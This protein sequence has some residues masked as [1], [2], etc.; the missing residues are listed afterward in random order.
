[1]PES[2]AI[3]TR[4]PQ[5][6]TLGRRTAFWL[7]AGTLALLLFASSAPSPLYVVYQAEW[8]FST[9]TLTSV[10]AVY[11]LG[12]L[13]ALVITGSV[14]DHVGRRP[15]LLVGLGLEVVGM[16]L[17]ARA[18]DVAWLFAAR[19]LQGVA[20]GIAMGAI[21][22]ALIDLEPSARL[23]ATLGVAA[24]MGG[25]AAG[26]LG[27]G[28]LVQYGPDPTRLIFWMLLGAFV[29]A[30]ILASALPETVRRGGPWV[31]SLRPRLAVPANLR[32]AF[33]GTIPCLVATWAL[34]GLILSL[35]PSLTAGV[36]GD[37]SHVA[38][39]LPIFIMAGISAVASVRLR[40][41]HARSTAR[42]GLGAMIVGV[43]V[44]LGALAAGSTA[45]FLVA[46]A[47]AGLG[48]GPAFAGAFRALS[49]RAGAAERGGLVSSILAVSYLAF[50]L[51]AVAAG[52]A[53]TDLGLRE[54]ANIY[55]AVLI[56]LALVALGL[57]GRL[58]D[59]GSAGPARRG[60]RVRAGELEAVP[61]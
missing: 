6:F 51:P 52:A 43:G 25:L 22:A 40:A 19:T 44:A 58:E 61:R 12:L 18:G 13:A 56:V 45:L 34:G 15:T 16:L 27:A 53:V 7:L 14:S 4:R 21:S 55:G 42:A 33:V 28:V 29:V 38:G 57:S 2:T 48:F 31:H 20:T 3:Q 59:P 9:I 1:M 23:G 36:L 8:G 35:G 54:T 17:F 30:T 32:P 26:A 49:S 5:G 11:A 47:I 41:A 46:T 39:G 24:P 37:P 60:A 50:S 10:F